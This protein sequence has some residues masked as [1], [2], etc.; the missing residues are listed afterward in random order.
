MS[1]VSEIDDIK[2]MELVRHVF[3]LE[4]RC[5]HLKWKVSDLA[6]QCKVSRPLVYYRLGR[7]KLEILNSCLEIIASEFYGLNPKRTELVK[8][9]GLMESIKYTRS[10]FLTTPELTV[11]YI[12]WS[13]VDSPLRDKL[14]EID[15]RYQQKLKHL[16]PHLTKVQ[17]VGVQAVLQGL[18]TTPFVEDSTISEVLKWLPGFGRK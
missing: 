2:V 14:K 6:R 5:G 7:N 17:T 16:F 8:K 18:I 11:F 12:K 4:S 10:L 1:Q 15:E 13:A 9:G 3:V